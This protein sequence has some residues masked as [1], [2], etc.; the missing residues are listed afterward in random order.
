MTLKAFIRG[1]DSLSES[2]KRKREV[3]F[4]VIVGAITTVIAHVSFVFFDILIKGMGID[5]A[6]TAKS[7]ADWVNKILSWCIAVVF[8]FY[9]SRY[10]VFL[11]KG[12]IGKEFRD[13]VSSRIFT[14]VA[15]DLGLWQVV[16]WIVEYGFGISR[17]ATIMTIL[18]IDMTWLY[19]INIVINVFVMIG[20]YFFSKFFVFRKRKTEEDGAGEIAE[21]K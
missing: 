17:D 10:F 19:G 1:D 16:I 4:Y 15:F 9:T 8:S 20:N 14:L 13:F 18:G 21:E 5:P 3:L 2:E 7:I 11:S 12:P 6:S